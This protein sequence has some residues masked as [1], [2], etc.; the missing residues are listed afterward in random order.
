VEYVRPGNHQP[1]PASLQ[2]RM[3][4]SFLAKEICCRPENPSGQQLLLGGPL[5]GN[6]FARLVEPF[7]CLSIASF[8]DIWLPRY[9]NF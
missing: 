5:P 4:A 3:R 7:S 1:F 6:T 9:M 2:L 8:M